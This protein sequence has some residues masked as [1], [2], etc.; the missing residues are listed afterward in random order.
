MIG[1]LIGWMI[2]LAGLSVLVRDGLVWI[3]TGRWAPIALGQLW[4]GSRPVEPQPPPGRGASLHSPISVGPDHRH[5]PLMLGLCGI[6]G[7]GLV[8][9]VPLRPASAIK[10]PIRHR[11]F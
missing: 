6:D 8:I 9:L 4:F 10:S 11:P 3:N 7:L 2:L 1:R 5:G